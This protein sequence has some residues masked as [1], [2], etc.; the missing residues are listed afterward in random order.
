M[1]HRLQCRSN[2]PAANA[3]PSSWL[4]PPVSLSSGV[5]PFL[6]LLLSVVFVPAP[7]ASAADS[8][9]WRTGRDLQNFLRKNIGGAGLAW[10][11]QPIREAVANLS[12]SSGIRVAMLLDRRIDPETRLEL[13]MGDVPFTDALARIGAA[14]GADFCQIGHVIY[15]GP[16]SITHRLRTVSELRKREVR[17]LPAADARRFTAYKPFAWDDLAEPRDLLKAIAAEADATI[18][19]LDAVPHD[20]WAAADLPSMSLTDRLTVVAGQYDLTFEVGLGGTTLRLVPIPDRVAIVRSYPVGQGAPEVAE[21]L[22]GAFVGCKIIVTGTRIEVEGRVEDH[23]QI[24]EALAG[25]PI[26]KPAAEAPQGDLDRIRIDSFVA[27]NQQLGALIRAIASRLKLE[28]EFDG[29]ALV[30]AKISLDQIVSAELKTGTV[31]DL[32]DKVMKPHGLGYEI[33]GKK[34][35]V[36]PAKKP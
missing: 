2:R 22:A 18:E 21:K 4:V 7:T 33:Q 3:A 12:R 35:L 8:I 13:A 30:A 28:A 27:E 10:S 15:F 36:R 1:I 9:N 32:L 6:A 26:R 16:S 14:G 19:N 17:E 29:P 34:L 24:V 23:L 20:L 5:L 31:K 11:G 25:K